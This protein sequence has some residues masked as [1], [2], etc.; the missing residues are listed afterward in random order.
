[1]GNLRLSANSQVSA[2]IPP[3]VS[4]AGYVGAVILLVLTLARFAA[5]VFWTDWNRWPH[6]VSLLLIIALTALAMVTYEVLARQRWH[7]RYGLVWLAADPRPLPVLAWS[8]FV[9]FLATGAV[10]AF[11]WALVHSHHYF[12]GQHFAFTRLFYDHVLGAYGLLGYP[13]H[14]FTLRR[15]G[16]RAFE[17][18]DYALLTLL[19]GRGLGLWTA[20]KLARW[21]VL[22]GR[23]RRIMR[24][25]R[26][27]KAYLVHLV[28]LFFLTLMTSFFAGEYAA[29]AEHLSRVLGAGFSQERLF[30]QYHQVY[31][32]LYHLVF[33]LDVGIAIIGYTLASRWLDNRSKSV[34]MT[35]YGW[36]V[37]L[38]CYPPMNAGFTDRFIGYGIPGTSPLITAEW[39]LMI[40]MVMILFCF[41]VYL[42]A[43]LALGL[44]FSNLNHRGVVTIG[45]YRYL[46]HPAYTM[47]N[48]AWWL[49]NTQVLTNAW[50]A[51][52][53]LL[54]N[55]IYVLR[56]I[57]EERHLLR[58]PEYR[59]Y[60]QQVPGRFWPRFGKG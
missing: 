39:A 13:Y 27:R 52:A 20:G 16:Q 23:G 15:L 8:A 30:T 34:D 1:M 53:L 58:D 60:Q 37:V 11:G 28:N 55:G 32:S 12:Q 9:R 22:V 17:F 6:E 44:R 45:P 47:K 56:G 14:L 10:L 4:L 41:L 26:V 40:L 54:W 33:V 21:P 51:L 38:L 59:A 50:A 36:L 48:L 24:A 43:T 57:T 5:E 19:G 42:W 46:R 3:F 35:C 29:F 7:R 2:P 18:N 25:R 49:D 31:L